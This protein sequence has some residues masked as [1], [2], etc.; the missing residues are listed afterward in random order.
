MSWSAGGGVNDRQVQRAE[1]SDRSERTFLLVTIATAV[2]PRLQVVDVDT[3]A[4]RANYGEVSTGSDVDGLGRQT[5]SGTK[6]G[7]GV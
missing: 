2:Q 6:K 5:G 4:G 7:G 3:A 1:L